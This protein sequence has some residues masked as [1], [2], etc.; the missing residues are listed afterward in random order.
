MTQLRRMAAT[1]AWGM[2]SVA[3]AACLLVASAGTARADGGTVSVRT[4]Y[5]VPGNPEPHTECPFQVMLTGYAPNQ[6][7]TLD[8]R[9][10]APTAPEGQ[11]VYHQTLTVDGNG[12]LTVTVSSADLNLTGISTYPND[13]DAFNLKLDPSAGSAPD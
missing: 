1:S 13:S 2:L 9:A 4:T 11:S 3:A 12:N 5:Q 10:V 7:L 8:L 6:V